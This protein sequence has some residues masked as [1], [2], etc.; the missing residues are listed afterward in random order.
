MRLYKCEWPDGDV[1]MILARNKEEALDD[2][3]EIGN[4]DIEML[5]EVRSFMVTFA[6]T[7]VEHPEVDEP[8]FEWSLSHLGECMVGVLPAIEEA[9][10]RLGSYVGA[11]D[12]MLEELDGNPTGDECDGNC[13]NCEHASTDPNK[14]GT[15]PMQ[16]LAEEH[17]HRPSVLAVHEVF[18][19]LCPQFPTKLQKLFARNVEYMCFG[20][21]QIAAYPPL[22]YLVGVVQLNEQGKGMCAIFSRQNLVAT[23]PDDAELVKQAEQ[24][25]QPSDMHLPVLLVGPS[26]KEAHVINVPQVLQ[27]FN[28]KKEAMAATTSPGS[29]ENN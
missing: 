29:T 12:P 2:L 14:V 10:A 7:E 13:A 28:A 27:S 6:P 9:I 8:D 4:A 21:S 11:G 16:A 1:T 24:G 22:R 3:D 23:H 5:T 19:D 26:R 18:P 25:I 17:L 15:G 20:L